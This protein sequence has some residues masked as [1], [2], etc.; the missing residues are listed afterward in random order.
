M[1][2]QKLLPRPVCRL[3]VPQNASQTHEAIWTNFTNFRQCHL[4]WKQFWKWSFTKSEW[5][6]W[7][8]SSECQPLRC[9]HGMKTEDYLEI[10]LHLRGCIHLCMHAKTMLSSD[11]HTRPHILNVSVGL[12]LCWFKMLLVFTLDFNDTSYDILYIYLQICAALVSQSLWVHSH[13]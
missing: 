13:C 2:R 1:G 9:Q 10:C 7:F 12:L 11:K 5:I 3:Q 8:G 6:K 4:D